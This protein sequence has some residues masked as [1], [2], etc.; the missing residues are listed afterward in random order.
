VYKPIVG[1]IE[2]LILE[3]IEKPDTSLFSVKIKTENTVEIQAADLKV[4]KLTNLK[5][6]KYTIESS[7]LEGKTKSN[8]KH[9]EITAWK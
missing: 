2:K 7:A 6:T 3:A 1:L 9:L 5:T 8:V 4:K